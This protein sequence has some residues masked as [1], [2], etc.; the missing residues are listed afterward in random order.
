VR[1]LLSGETSVSVSQTVSNQYILVAAICS[2]LL[3]K[4]GIGQY[5][6]G[7]TNSSIVVTSSKRKY[8]EM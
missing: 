7:L 5:L 3:I 6:K 8:M 4:S 1:H 2:I